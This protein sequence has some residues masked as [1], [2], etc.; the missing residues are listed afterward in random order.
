MY[1]FSPAAFIFRPEWDE[2]VYET[3]EGQWLLA[4]FDFYRDKVDQGAIYDI[5]SLGIST[6]RLLVSDDYAD[7]IRGESHRRRIEQSFADI[8]AQEMQ[9]EID[10]EILA[11]LTSAARGGRYDNADNLARWDAQKLQWDE[12]PVIH[13]TDDLNPD[14]IRAHARR[15]D[16]R[17]PYS[18]K[19]LHLR[20]LGVKV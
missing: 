15:L 17:R 18:V 5:T 14:T 12:D 19:A 13:T 16:E 2:T 10:K 1:G 8:M 4:F 11:T 6:G 20:Q 9:A 3:V 7:R